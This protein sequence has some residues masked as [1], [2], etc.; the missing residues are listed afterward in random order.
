MCTYFFKLR[1]FVR[2]Y[3][4]NYVQE[5]W[6]IQTALENISFWK[7]EEPSPDGIFYIR[8]GEYNLKITF[9]LRWYSGRGIMNSSM[10]RN[11]LRSLRYFTA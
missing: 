4:N 9:F 6:M 10:Q 1:I 3:E 11:S 8:K 7:I 5:L 2:K